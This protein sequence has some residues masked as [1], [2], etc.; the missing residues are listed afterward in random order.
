MKT[1]V[2]NSLSD[3]EIVASEIA[4]QLSPGSVLALY[5]E[6]GAGKTALVRALVKHL[7]P[8]CLPLVHSPTFAIVNEYKG[9]E[10]SIYHFDFYRITDEDD[11][12]STGYFELL[13]TDAVLITEWSENV[14]GAIP[15]D[16]IRI[17][18]DKTSETGRTFTI[19]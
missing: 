18:I 19:C 12:Y 10:I 16:A 14:E 1:L 15:Q 4:K 11:L 9:N 17:R 2:S 3:T 13:G 5:G 7:C 6:M 8:E